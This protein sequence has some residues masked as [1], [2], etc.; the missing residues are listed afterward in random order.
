[1]TPRGV[2]LSVS[3]RRSE[4][5]PKMGGDERDGLVVDVADALTLNQNV[6]WDRCAREGTPAAL[7]TIEN[8]RV[9]AGVL[10][11]SRAHG[12]AASGAPATGSR[13][14][15]GVFVRRAVQ[16][17]L[18][19]AAFWA[20]AS[21]MLGLW[22]WDA[23]RREYGELA[24]HLMGLVA[25]HAATACL[26]LLAGRRDRRT[27]LL[28]SYC[29]LRA[30]LVSPFALLAF[31]RGEPPV[32]PFGYPDF[33][34]PYV[35]PFMFAPAFLWAFARECPRVHRGTRL[36]GLARRMVPI[37]VL[38]GGLVWITS[39]TWLVL[40]RAG[41]VAPAVSWLVFD[42]IFASLDLL[43]FGAVVVVLL[44]AH[45]AP[46]DESRRVALF[47]I[48]FL[49]FVGLTS[50]HNVVEAFSPGDWLSNYRRSPAI[51]VVALLRFPG[52]A[53]LWYSVLAVR[54]P[55]L[56]EVVRASFR[57]LLAR[58]WL[59]GA[60][61]AAPAAA[62]GWR[63]ASRPEQT[64][65]AVAADPV[66]RSL[67][68]ASVFLLLVAAGRGRLLL[69]LDAWLY[70]ETADQ[71]QA[72]ADA[73]A[74][75]A[76]VGRMA[77]VS[78]IVRR[79]ARRGCGT[80][81]SLLVRTD[82]SAEAEDLEDPDGEAPPLSR[83]SAIVCMLETAGGWL[84]VH[85]QDEASDF[86]LLPHEDRG[87]VVASGADAVVAL[88]GPGA[89]L[90]GVLVAGR[91]LDG[92]IVRKVDL[93]F[94]EALG[95]AAALAAGRVL[96]MRAGGAG[97]PDAAPAEEC[98]VCG[99]VSEAGEPAE[100][101]CGSA[102]VETE[103]PKL[104]AGK[105]RL[106]RCL[107]RG[108]MGAAYLARDVRLERDVAVKTLTGVSVFRLMGS[109]PEAWAMATVTHPAVAQIHGIE[110]WRGRPFLVVEFLS[111][112]TLEDRLRR[113]PVPAARALDIAALLADAL[114]ALHEAGYLHG[115]VKPSNVG[116][117]SD[118]SPKLLDFGLAREA[119]DVTSGGGT[120]RYL[121]PEVLSGRP[122]DEADDV[123][124]LCVMLYEMVSGEHPFAGGG[125]G[126]VRDSIRRQRLRRGAPS[127][128]ALAFTASVLTARRSAR[129]ASGRAFADGLRGVRRREFFRGESPSNL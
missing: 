75:L 112:G 9:V 6:D 71:R 13:L 43:A 115:D 66:V 14:P 111:R 80:P 44:R 58:G 87:W 16:A 34:F 96:V 29:L 49:L 123:W 28:G 15:G 128:E 42:W 100:C 73:A 116:F 86:D 65:G 93:P 106:T 83:A 52:L 55:H 23:F 102:Y 76:K 31:L 33:G 85:S 81:V 79:T 62:L 68:A 61:V 46:A 67:A 82:A 41:R 4:G 22:G 88:P 91:R 5:M 37:S 50:A 63:L 89:E 48:G 105:Y 27:W 25:G 77:A 8:M 56:R 99:H 12:D 84:R 38:I 36:D 129:P 24:V 57:R 21:L 11:G 107:G 110:S 118:G 70:P 114:A 109:K 122:A 104:L 127:S 126:E 113:G 20:A 54:V 3:T 74:A 30:T 101:D 10:A 125:A 39:V 94:L 53:L 51:A 32:E 98:P 90:S 103:A 26:F 121:S 17:L 35:F 97:S 92:R 59:L 72:L 108:G 7:R 64:V 45:T 124:S 117:A 19:F 40:A 78:R 2:G 120:A 69:R 60:G 47:T 1:M 119:N 18:A 95:A